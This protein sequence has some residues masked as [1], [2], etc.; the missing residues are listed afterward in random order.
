MNELAQRLAKLTP[1]Q[2]ALVEARLRQHNKQKIL[3][4]RPEVLAKRSL[5]EPV[6]F[7]FRRS[8]YGF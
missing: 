1:E 7:P 6:A 8:G 3:E 5:E 4:A 2:R